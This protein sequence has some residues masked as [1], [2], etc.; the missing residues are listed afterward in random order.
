MNRYRLVIIV[1]LFYAK[2][3]KKF[4]GEFDMKLVTKS[5]FYELVNQGEI[6]IGENNSKQ[7]FFL[8][9][10]RFG[11]SLREEVTQINSPVD[12]DADEKK[13]RLTKFRIGEKP[14]VPNKFYLASSEEEIFLPNNIMGYINTRSK[15]ARLG[16]E[17]ARSSVYVIPGFGGRKPTPF[18]FEIT[19]PVEI[20][21]LKQGIPYGFL[22]LF[23]FEENISTI[24]KSYLDRFPFQG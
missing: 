3:R 18:I 23:E 12:F 13:L 22:L 6:G 8:D 16:F 14:L 5:R 24:E 11:L 15:F 21:G 1:L 10:I 20:Y 4:E 2:S 19:V 9:D 17:L 7:S